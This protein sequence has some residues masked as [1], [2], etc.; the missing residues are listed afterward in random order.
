MTQYKRIQTQQEGVIQAPAEKVWQQ[1][2]HWGGIMTWW[3]EDDPPAPLYKA[4]LSP[5][6]SEQHLPRTRDCYFDLSQLPPG[7]DPSI[8]P[9]MVQETLL[10]VDDETRF[11]YYNMEGIGPFGL[12]SYLATTEVNELG[13]NESHLICKSRFDAPS[14]APIEMLKGFIESIHSRGIIR[15]FKSTLE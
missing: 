3:P 7:M 14:D 6:L 8:L 1:L 9:N 12:R 5:G 13:E 15:G 2:V 11:M 10:H 4:P